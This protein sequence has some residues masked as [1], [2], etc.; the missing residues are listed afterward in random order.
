MH[1]IR[2]IGPWEFST[3]PVAND[4]SA[5]AQPDPGRVKTPVVWNALFGEWRGTA[6]CLRRFNRPTNIDA[7]TRIDVTV[8][9]LLGSARVLLNEELL[10]DATRDATFSINVTG[11]LKL[12]NRLVI[13][14]T[15]GPDGN[16]AE[17]ELW[18][19]VAIDIHE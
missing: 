15:L 9:D 1:R 16:S 19:L 2:L 12:H 13:E 7:D 10:V 18:S 17:Q 4:S 11:K 6:R 14:L 3:S 8:V 5:A